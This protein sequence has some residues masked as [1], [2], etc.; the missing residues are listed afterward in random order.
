MK[1]RIIRYLVFFFLLTVSMEA[2][3]Q[4]NK[5]RDIH[6]VKK[7]ETLYSIAHE[8][9]ITIEELTNAN[10]EMKVPGYQLKKGDVVFIPFS[11]RAP[12]TSSPA[13]TVATQQNAARTDV[14]N[15]EIRLGV[16]LPLHDI[17]G[18]GRRMTEYYRGVLMACD[19]L[20][21]EGLSIRVDAFNA[22]EQCNIN[23][24][25][26]NPQLAQCDV[27][28][29]PLYSAQMPAVSA[30]ARQHDIKLFIPFSINAPQIKDNPGI[31]QVYQTPSEIE[32]SIAARYMRQFKDYHTVLIDCND[33]AS[34]K[35]SFTSLLRS[36]LK[37][38]GRS[39]SITSTKS[40][41]ENFAK[42]FSKKMPNVVILNTERSPQLNVVFAKLN[43]LA[44]NA[45]DLR[46]TLFGYT[47]WMMYTRY[48]LDN[49]YRF[50]V[51]IPA[52]FYTNPLSSATRRFEQK[53]RWNFHEDMLAALPR[54]AITGFDHTY[55]FLKGLH[56]YGTGFNG[57]IGSIGYTPIQTP[58]GF[59]RIG[60][61]GGW[62]NKRILM[63]N[64]APSKQ[65]R[66]I[67]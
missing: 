49:Y 25:L 22:S 36:Q 14:R 54:F 9:S 7:K 66:V 42:A 19:S 59:E 3:S 45:P 64:Y 5:W 48:N 11:S 13:K 34:T 2:Y 29:G 62:Q 15:R 57:A 30:F 44:N 35:G 58:L 21:C 12:Q 46:I 33:S 32:A 17:N 31:Y 1:I 65:I 39:I 53:Y 50:N 10:P 60:S 61:N 67:Y 28:F 56:E 47:E 38:A 23:I 27:I 24:L 37:S 8:Y 6:K 52:T 18:D 41:E 63:V 43:G 16:L 40:S 4:S 51:Y 55:F 26:A 20:R